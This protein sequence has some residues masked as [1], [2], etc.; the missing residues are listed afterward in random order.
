MP[1]KN[2]EHT[3]RKETKYKLYSV[4]SGYNYLK[5]KTPLSESL[6]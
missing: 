4:G 5:G 1:K 3:L 2:G 6:R